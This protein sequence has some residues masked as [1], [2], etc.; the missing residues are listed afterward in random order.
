MVGNFNIYIKQTNY[1]YHEFIR[2]HDTAKVRVSV[3]NDAKE[4]VS[5]LKKFPDWN[6]KEKR[7]KKEKENKIHIPELWE[8]FKKCNICIIS[9]PYGEEEKQQKK[10]FK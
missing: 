3:L 6:V 5:V 4:R 9:V 1:V 8:N 10:Y 7:I 2:R